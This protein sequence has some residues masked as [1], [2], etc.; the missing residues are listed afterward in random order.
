MGACL[1]VW[2][3]KF[4]E[5]K[6]IGGAHV[7]AP[8]N[9]INAAI[10]SWVAFIKLPF[11]QAMA[12]IASPQQELWASYVMAA[13]E[14]PRPVGLVGSHEETKEAWKRLV[15]PELLQPVERFFEKDERDADLARGT[16]SALERTLQSR[17]T[18]ETELLD[19][20]SIIIASHID[21]DAYATAIRYSRV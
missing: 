8:K 16:L 17:P 20:M 1:S 10:T 14:K 13:K 21:D 19:L 11:E 3:E 7:R 15:D 9:P 18:L 5:A 2:A 6:W 12:K 4:L